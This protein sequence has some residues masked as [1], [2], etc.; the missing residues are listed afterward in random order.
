MFCSNIFTNELVFGIEVTSVW[1]DAWDG[2]RLARIDGAFASAEG[3]SWVEPLNLD[4]MSFTA[5]G[6]GSESLEVL[7][8]ASITPLRFVSGASEAGVCLAA[9]KLAAINE[10]E[11]AR[12]DWTTGSPRWEVCEAC[13]T[14]LLPVCWGWRSWG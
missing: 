14:V 12:A 11:R 5:P 4:R 13:E 6:A 8:E 1:S 7:F 9:A 10:G 3:G 2:G